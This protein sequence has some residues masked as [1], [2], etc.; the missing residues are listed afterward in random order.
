LHHSFQ[1]QLLVDFS[2]EQLNKVQIYTFASA[3]N[4]FS[5]PVGKSDLPP[6]DHVEHFVNT[7]DYISLIGGICASL[8]EELVCN[9]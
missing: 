2:F 1:D 5:A 4:H 8:P 9:R 3:A 7:R 6:F